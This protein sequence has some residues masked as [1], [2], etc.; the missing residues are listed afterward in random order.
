MA[1]VLSNIPRRITACVNKYFDDNK[2]SFL[3]WIEG[4]VPSIPS[5][6]RWA[7]LRLNGPKVRESTKNQFTIEM[8]VDIMCCAQDT[9]NLYT[10][11]D[12]AGHFMNLMVDIAITDNDGSPWFCLIRESEVDMIP[13]GIIKKENNVR[14]TSVMA[15]YKG[16]VNVGH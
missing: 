1:K 2:A 3:L 16:E 13:W 14:G 15:T 11:E 4:T 9:F 5:Q 7:E 10:L 8:S 12:I 6:S